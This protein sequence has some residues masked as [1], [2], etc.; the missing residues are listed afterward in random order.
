MDLGTDEV[1][2]LTL[3]R[4]QLS[5]VDHLAPL[6]RKCLRLEQCTT[7]RAGVQTHV[8]ISACAPNICSLCC[9][10]THVRIAHV[11][12]SDPPCTV[13]PTTRRR[14]RTCRAASLSQTTRSRRTAA[15]RTFGPADTRGRPP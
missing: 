2:D 8:R 1:Q 4:G 5:L 7:R 11:L 3:P 13:S 14:E 15:T 9:S 10:R 6:H 12:M